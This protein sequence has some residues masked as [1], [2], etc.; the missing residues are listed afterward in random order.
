MRESS[1]LVSS[2]GCP[3]FA[4]MTIVWFVPFQ[5]TSRGAM[6]WSG[7][8]RVF[9]MRRRGD[10]ADQENAGNDSRCDDGERWRRCPGQPFVGCV[11]VGSDGKR[12][13]IERAQ[14][15][16]RRQLLH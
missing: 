2:P 12:V 8:R 3:L 15:Q 10:A 9:A 13:E 6:E 7:L 5:N 16:G 14:H 1:F 4:G 11:I